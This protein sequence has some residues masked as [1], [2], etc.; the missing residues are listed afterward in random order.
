MSLEMIKNHGKPFLA[1]IQ[2]ILCEG[3]ITVEN[4]YIYLCQDIM[5]GNLCEERHG[6]KHSWVVGTKYSL[7]LEENEVEDLVIIETLKPMTN[8]EIAKLD[9]NDLYDRFVKI[10]QTTTD[11]EL[12]RKLFLKFALEGSF[13]AVMSMYY[14]HQKEI[15]ETVK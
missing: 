9:H 7:D 13:S 4:G 15:E 6:Y 3:K 14:A 5:S 12:L 8:E 11:I 10:I 1:R 2:G